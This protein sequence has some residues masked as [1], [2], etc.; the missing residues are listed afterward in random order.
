ML[1]RQ[2][3][4]SLI[5]VMVAIVLLGFGL[6]SLIGLQ[7]YSVT[8]SKNAA[9]RGIATMLAADIADTL[10]ANPGAAAEYDKA[11]AFDATEIA[12]ESWLPL[13]LPPC[14]YPA[15]SAAQIVQTNRQALGIRIKSSLQAGTYALATNS[16]A[17]FAD[18]WVMW[19]EA[20]GAGE[21]AFDNCP[22]TV[23]AGTPAVIPRC[24][25]MRVG[26]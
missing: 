13:P 4:A 6:L 14:E 26:L 21:S 18:L 17:G 19:A 15:C 8:A 1:N 22:A 3:G 2:Y 24:L 7:G 9:N 20:G 23:T 11:A 5:E 12:P 25:Y 16:A 10:R